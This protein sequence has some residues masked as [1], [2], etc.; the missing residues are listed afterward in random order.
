MVVILGLHLALCA[1]LVAQDDTGTTQ[2]TRQFGFFEI[3]ILGGGMPGVF[4]LIPIELLSIASLAFII[5]HFVTIQRDKLVPPEI[6]VELET[7]LDEE[8]YEEAINLCEATKNYI[9][10]IVG[11]AIARV[12]EGYEAMEMAAETATDEENLKLM[13]KIQWLNLFGNVA[14][15]M[16]LLGTVTGMTTAFGSIA[17]SAGTVSPQELAGGIFTAL[18]TT[19]WGLIVAIPSL[20]FYFIFR[21]KVQRL[22]FELSGVALEIVERFKPVAEGT[23]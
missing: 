10:N 23:K 12:G 3:Y 8:Q 7:L 20:A 13:H 16:G 5:E 9:T 4:F 6:V 14:P 15:M 1:V 17:G 11:A 19:V 21:L 2:P 18:V 22:A